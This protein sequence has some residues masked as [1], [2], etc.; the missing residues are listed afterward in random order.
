MEQLRATIGK[1]PKP[2]KPIA[3]QVAEQ[4]DADGRELKRQT[5]YLPPG[6]HDQ[7]REAAFTKR[8]SMQEVVRQALDMWFADNGLQSWDE[9]KRQRR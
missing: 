3:E 2:P 5:L 6:V 7:L 1:L 9:A 8:V 4:I